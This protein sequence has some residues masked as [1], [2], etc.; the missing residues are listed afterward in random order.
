MAQRFIGGVPI[1]GMVLFGGG[2]SSTIVR[3]DRARDH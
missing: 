3:A 1:T 2:L